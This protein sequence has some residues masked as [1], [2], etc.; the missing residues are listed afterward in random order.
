MIY[1]T[2]DWRISPPR[3]TLVIQKE[4]LQTTFGGVFPAQIRRDWAACVKF[5][6][7]AFTIIPSIQAVAEG[8]YPYNP[9]YPSLDWLESTYQEVVKHFGLTT[10]E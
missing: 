3:R 2:L 1:Q 4:R 10:L 8:I 7:A 6:G 5:A 9:L